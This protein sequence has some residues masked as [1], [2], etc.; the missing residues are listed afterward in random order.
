MTL[1]LTIENVANLPD[2]G[3]LSVTVS[4]KRGIDIGRDSHLDWTL[5][6]PTRYISGKH[7]EVR[8]KDGGYWLYDVS[9]N[10][11]MLYGNDSRLNGPH[12]LRNGDRL[13]IGHY[14]VVA[15]VDGEGV[16]APAPAFKAQPGNYDNLWTPTEDAAPPVDRS[17]VMSPREAPAPL[18]PDF[19]DWAAEVPQ[20]FEGATPRIASHFDVDLPAGPPQ[21]AP[22]PVSPP[23]D[24]GLPPADLDWAFGERKQEPA[25]PPPPA[26]P[27]PR[28]PPVW[29]SEP[30]GPWGGDGHAA[31]PSSA[32][33]P[34]A[35]TAGEAPAPGSPAPTAPGMLP[36][37]SP[38][39]P[40]AVI[41]PAAVSAASPPAAA[42]AA[43]PPAAQT[44]PPADFMRRLAHAAGVPEQVFTQ[45]SPDQIA[46]QL[47]AAMRLLVE[48]VRQLLNARL[49]AKR[50]ARSANQTMIQALDNNPLKF[51]P[52]A[53]DAMRIMF[54]PPTRSY[55][56]ASRAIE[57]SF[58]DLKSHQLQTYA[59]M[60]QALRMLIDDL[61]PQ[62]IDR[63]TEAD[64]GIAAMVGSRKARLWEA[65]VARWQ[66][67]TRRQEGGIVDVFMQYFAECYDR[68][69]NT[70]R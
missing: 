1:T 18:R 57:Q 51:S 11:T 36:A 68:G 33:A 35:P 59:A 42:Q 13:V 15:A 67:K 9:T 39:P 41:Q 3:P 55:L 49:E 53:E 60:Q 70:L 54:G 10:G 2:G 62:A 64:R 14:I 24:A 37:D 69:T 43:P 44:M 30:D 19:L 5:P 12:L 17:Q 4:G 23:A 27:N 6:D 21:S 52:S 63:E 40:A 58:G 66:A 31:P 46:D 56:S 28:R 20:T 16:P 29:V 45:Q 61:D 22:P 25:P 26:V 38:L 48:N 47:G 50:L 8:Y 65:Y 32:L 7:C 34:A